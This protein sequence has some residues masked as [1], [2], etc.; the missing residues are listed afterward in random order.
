ML[1]KVLLIVTAQL[2]NTFVETMFDKNGLRVA[3]KSQVL[4]DIV[5]SEIYF[6]NAGPGL[7]TKLEFLVAVPNVFQ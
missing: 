6:S 2:I 3:V 4:P 1:R 7:V 5:I